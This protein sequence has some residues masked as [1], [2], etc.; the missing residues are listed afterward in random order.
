MCSRHNLRAKLDA[1][2]RP[3]R[4]A[5][6][7]RR[8]SEVLGIPESHFGFL[9]IDQ[10][11]S[12]RCAM[13]NQLRNTE[14]QHEFMLTARH[15]IEIWTESAIAHISDKEMACVLFH[16]RDHET[17]AILINVD[18]VVQAL[19]P[20]RDAG[21]VYDFMICDT[22]CRHGICVDFGFYS[23]DGTYYA[24]GVCQAYHW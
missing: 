3:V 15:E 11:N 9:P 24:E 19:W 22:G 6:C 5:E 21:L 13:I 8:L 1:H 4:I 18:R 23:S 10:T 2:L 20:M 14:P 16:E 17:G 12:W 7:S